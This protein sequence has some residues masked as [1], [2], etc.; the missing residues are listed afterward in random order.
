MVAIFLKS[1]MAGCALLRLSVFVPIL[2]KASTLFMCLIMELAMQ[3]RSKCR[4]CRGEFWLEYRMIEHN[5]YYVIKG[6]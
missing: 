5:N 2:D 4:V 3:V 6:L 1:M